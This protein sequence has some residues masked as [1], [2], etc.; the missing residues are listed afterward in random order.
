MGPKKRKYSSPTA[1]TTLSE[2][3]TEMK[4][5]TGW[6]SGSTKVKKKSTKK[7]TS[8]SGIGYG[9]ASTKEA[10][11]AAEKKQAAAASVENEND[12]IGELKPFS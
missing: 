8:G 6:L 1:P 5:F 12:E 9:S 2:L 10:T 11:T 3:I 7:I 4:S